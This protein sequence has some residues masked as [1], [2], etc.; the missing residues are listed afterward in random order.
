MYLTNIKT[1]TRARGA[2]LLTSDNLR[3]TRTDNGLLYESQPPPWSGHP[4]RPVRSHNQRYAPY[5]LSLSERLSLRNHW[6]GLRSP[7]FAEH[8]EAQRQLVDLVQASDK[9]EHQKRHINNGTSEP[10][11]FASTE[12]LFNRL[13]YIP[14]SIP[15]HLSDNATS[16]GQ[17]K[18]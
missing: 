1:F 17:M 3:K 6:N 13:V 10:D 12:T 16:T 2:G 4:P 5:K 14:M 15:S 8:E 18:L 9:G 11:I 7:S